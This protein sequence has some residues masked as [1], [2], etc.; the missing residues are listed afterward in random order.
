MVNDWIVAYLLLFAS[1]IS[2]PDAKSQ[3]KPSIIKSDAQWKVHGFIH[4]LEMKIQV[5]VTQQYLDVVHS[6]CDMGKSMTSK[7][8]SACW[9]L[10]DLIHR[11]SVI[12]EK[13]KEFSKMSTTIDHLQKV[14]QESVLDNV[15]FTIL[16]DAGEMYSKTID[17]ITHI[18]EDGMQ[19]HIRTI[20]FLAS[21]HLNDMMNMEYRLKMIKKINELAN[22]DIFSITETVNRFEVVQNNLLHVCQTGKLTPV[23]QFLTQSD[24]MHILQEI[25]EHL[26]EENASDNDV[27]VVGKKQFILP[28]N[29]NHT[30]YNQILDVI[31]ISCYTF[32]DR[33]TFEINVPLIES[34]KYSFKHTNIRIPYN[35]KE[36][37]MGP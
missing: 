30:E 8:P 14:I 9:K 20:D 5:G 11:V 33:L 12:N 28:L 17:H 34:K 18:Q 35:Q 13:S 6:F 3:I 19:Q 21:I 22:L 37:Y 23:N 10:Q 25:E 32:G 29:T 31:S 16:T 2:P 27:D 7:Y 36:L 24:I 15:K 1:M 26:R 4:L